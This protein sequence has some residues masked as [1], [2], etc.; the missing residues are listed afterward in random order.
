M[1]I[2][3]YNLE[4]ERKYRSFS[5][6]LNFRKTLFFANFVIW[7]YLKKI[8]KYDLR[9]PKCDILKISLT[10]FSAGPAG[11]QGQ[12][13]LRLKPPFL[14]YSTAAK[15]TIPFGPLHNFPSSLTAICG[16]IISTQMSIISFALLLFN[17]NKSVRLWAI[18]HRPPYMNVVTE[19]MPYKM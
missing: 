7:P 1:Y 15:R 12:T 8:K 16:N 9:K 19:D 17:D 13:S 11:Y 3:L 18:H 14:L 5:H 6:Q 2:S 10:P 4:D